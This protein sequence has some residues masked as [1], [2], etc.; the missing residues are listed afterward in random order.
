MPAAAL[1]RL[2]LPTAPRHDTRLLCEA[3]AE[4]G[5]Q[6]GKLDLLTLV[7]LAP[8]PVKQSIHAYLAHEFEI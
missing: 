6:G 4:K 2:G 7:K 1:A 5:H 3:C 8:A